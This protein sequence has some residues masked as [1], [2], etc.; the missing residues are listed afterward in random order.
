MKIRNCTSKHSVI[1][2][3]TLAPAQA[4]LIAPATLGT[5]VLEAPPMGLGIAPAPPLAVAAA[6][7]VGIIANG[8]ISNGIVANI[9]IGNGLIA[10]R[11]LANRIAAAPLAVELVF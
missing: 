9:I 6:A 3:A 7:P 8:F 10:N 1:F 5:P 2:C 11:I 4:S